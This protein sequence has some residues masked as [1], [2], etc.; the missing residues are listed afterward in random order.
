MQSLTKFFQPKNY[1]LT[2]SFD[3]K[4]HFFDGQA[5]ISGMVDLEFAKIRLDAVDLTIKSV[6]INGIKTAFNYDDKFL[7][8]REVEQQEVKV[9][10]DFQGKITEQM[11]GIYPCNYE[12]DGVKKEIIATQFESHYAR[13]AFPCIDEPI[14]KAM[15]D[16][17]I[18][19]DA[20][21]TI[22]SNTPVIKQVDRRS[23]QLVRFDTTPKMSTYTLAFV[24]G[25]LVKLEGLTKSGVQVTAYASTAHQTTELEF[26]LQVALDAL[27]WYENYFGVAYPLPKCDHVALPDFAAG[28]MENWGLVT[29]REALF[30]TQPDTPVDVR[31]TTATVIT[32]ELAHMW[33]GNLVTMRWWDELW[34]NESLASIFENRCLTAIRPEF[35]PIDNFYASS[36]YT[37]L[38][39]DSLPGV[40]PILLP[41]NSPEEISTAFD[42][43]IVYA[44]GA[45]LMSMLENYLGE[46]NFRRGLSLFLEKYKFSCPSGAA[47]LKIFDYVSQ[48]PASQLMQ[49]WL[50]QAGYPKITVKQS[51][52]KLVLEQNR[53]GAENDTTTWSLPLKIAKK[54]IVLDGK[55]TTIASQPALI[56]GDAS[57][58]AV[59]KYAENLL[60]AILQK[61]CQ[62]NDV[63]QY[64]FLTSS[65]LLAQKNEFSL[66]KLFS[67]LP[68]F[69]EQDHYL[70]WLGLA[71]IIY[72]SKTILENSPESLTDLR[73]VVVKFTAPI[74]SKLGFEPGNHETVKTFKTRQVLLD[75]ALSLK[76]PDYL[77]KLAEQFKDD[78]TKIPAKNRQNII[79]AKVICHGE[80]LL[81]K[82]LLKVYTNCANPDLKD[83][84]ADGLCATE[85]PELVALLLE[86]TSQRTKIKAQ[87]IL[88]WFAEL[89]QSPVN[90]PAVWQ[91]LKDNFKELIKLFADSGDYADFIRVASGY[92]ATP[93]ELDDFSNF[94]KKYS[95]DPALTREIA[96]GQAQIKQKITQ[97]EQNLTGLQAQVQKMLS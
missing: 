83:D 46:D 95:N 93:N 11:Y 36:L 4:K 48:K 35:Q 40:Q 15:F 71:R 39:R 88:Y 18:I 60:P 49:T 72:S 10:I 27:D 44:K 89:I 73:D 54:S 1:Q 92:L 57:A 63:A 81:V 6:K 51:N 55:T 45:C 94:C 69:A 33:F 5:I 65:L 30:L 3:N 43:A 74:L 52:N 12:K 38:R 66:A 62:A 16:L 85:K 7:E 22:L 76:Q 42:G 87:D 26:G 37:A 25:D 77:A 68:K 82:K 9:E 96:V 8:I 59:V 80:E 34:L 97:I 53:F 14:A 58:F 21:L 20:D 32:H 28:A 70:V 64:Y 47:M 29:Y 23:K 19:A 2:F 50:A 79:A 67:Y 78:V 61:V 90:R 91:W 41:I 24:I 13:Y 17:T 31:E 86:A 75:L 56:N 84:L